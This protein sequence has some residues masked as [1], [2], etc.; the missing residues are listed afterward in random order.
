[1]WFVNIQVALSLALFWSLLKRR[2]DWTIVGDSSATVTAQ[3][4]EK[5]FQW[6]WFL[7]NCQTFQSL[8]NIQYLLVHIIFFYSKTTW[9]RWQTQILIFEYLVGTFGKLWIFPDELKA[10][11]RRLYMNLTQ[12]LSFPNCSQDS[13]MVECKI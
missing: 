11:D 10:S 3:Q 8:S 2:L 1:M 5:R 13:C 7:Y 12:I 4:K 6:K 9:L